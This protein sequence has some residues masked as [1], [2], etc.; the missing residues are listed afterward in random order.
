MR[1]QGLAAWVAYV[2]EAKEGKA[3]LHDAARRSR[4][5]VRAWK[6]GVSLRHRKRSLH[7]AAARLHA[8]GCL[9]RGLLAWMRHTY[10]K[11][12]GHVA[13][14]FRVRRLAC[15]VLRHWHEV[16]GP[17]CWGLALIK[18]WGTTQPARLAAA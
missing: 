7:A 17:D 6:V 9:R 5:A 11:H 8:A 3:A 10:Y 15:V 16:C 13:L 2:E 14:H 1:A 4:L 12:M 18:A